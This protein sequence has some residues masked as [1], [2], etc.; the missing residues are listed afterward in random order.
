RACW[1]AEEGVDGEGGAC[2]E[3]RRR[4]AEDRVMIAATASAAVSRICVARETRTTRRVR[5]TAARGGCEAVVVASHDT[6]PAK[7]EERLFRY[8]ERGVACTPR[9]RVRTCPT[10]AKTAVARRRRRTAGWPAT[11]SERRR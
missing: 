10:V 9:S 5:A 6:A 11:R 2:R 3:G 7:A 1:S 4:G 8:A